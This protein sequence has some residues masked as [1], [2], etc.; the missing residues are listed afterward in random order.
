MINEGYTLLKILMADPQPGILGCQWIKLLLFVNT[1]ALR[2]Y[3]FPGR[4]YFWLRKDFLGSG[5]E[6][7]W[8]SE[9]SEVFPARKTLISGIPHSPGGDR[10]HSLTFLTVKG[11]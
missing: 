8:I 5:T 7:S 1:S 6:D 10:D 4:E 3:T 11:Q 2:K 9:I